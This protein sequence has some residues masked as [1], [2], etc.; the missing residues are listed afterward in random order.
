MSNIKCYER[1][2]QPSCGFTHSEYLNFID[3]LRVSRPVKQTYE[4]A[5]VVHRFIVHNAIFSKNMHPHRKTSIRP[6]GDVT[7]AK[8]T[9]RIIPG[10]CTHILLYCGYHTAACFT[11]S[12]FFSLCFLLY[13]FFDA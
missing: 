10:A 2:L 4:A 8:D 1:A 5:F 11:Y 13:F 3:C 7:L 6:R 9:R 12:R